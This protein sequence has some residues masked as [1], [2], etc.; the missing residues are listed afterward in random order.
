MGKRYA[1]AKGTRRA[2]LKRF[3]VT[4]LRAGKGDAPSPLMAGHLMTTR[5]LFRHAAINRDRD[6]DREEK[7]M[8]TI[9]NNFAATFGIHLAE[10]YHIYFCDQHPENRQNEEY[11]FNER[12]GKWEYNTEANGEWIDHKM[13]NQRRIAQLRQEGVDPSLSRVIRIY[14]NPLYKLFLFFSE[15][16]RRWVF[17]EKDLLHKTHRRSVIYN[18]R[19][20]AYQAYQLKNIIFL[21]SFPLT[22]S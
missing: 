4:T 18:E 7:R 2:Y 6:I 14:S 11:I 10:F 21:R 9:L 3:S 19:G 22:R 16:H 8:N 12:T 1:R 17:Y 20:K 15:N 5:E 13:L